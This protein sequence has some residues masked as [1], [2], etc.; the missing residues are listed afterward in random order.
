MTVATSENVQLLRGYRVTMEVKV[1]FPETKH[2][3]LFQLLLYIVKTMKRA[4][5]K[6]IK[7]FYTVMNGANKS[8]LQ[9][10]VALYCHTYCI[11]LLCH[12]YRN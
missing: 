6:A 1:L 12:V 10:K 2:A 8:L 7:F 5:R 11:R 4:K 9:V 3:I